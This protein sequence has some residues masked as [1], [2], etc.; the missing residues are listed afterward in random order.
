MSKKLL[1]IAADIVQAQASKSGLSS[2][3]IVSSLKQVFGTL[4]EMQKTETEGVEVSGE[5]AV[6]AQAPERTDPQAS[7]QNDKII[8]LECGA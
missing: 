5:G 3:E 1:E 2:E 6:E 7:I 4:Q 8:C